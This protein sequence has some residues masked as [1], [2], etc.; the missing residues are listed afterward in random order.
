MTATFARHSQGAAEAVEGANVM[1]D[2]FGVIAMVAMTPLIALQI[3][4]YIF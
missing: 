1:I 2:L 3:P 4:G